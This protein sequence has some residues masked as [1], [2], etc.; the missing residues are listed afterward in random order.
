MAAPLEFDT[1]LFHVAE[2]L[3]RSPEG[4]EAKTHLYHELAMD[5][6]GMFSLGMHLIKVFG[7]RIPLSEVAEISTIGDIWN[8]LER[9]K[10]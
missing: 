3:G 10:E 4:L 2:F 8:A 7:V 1:F 9:H 5:S 6:L